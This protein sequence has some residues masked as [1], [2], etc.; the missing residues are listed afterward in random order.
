MCYKRQAACGAAVLSDQWC[1]LDSF[2]TP[3]EQILIARSRTDTLAALDM[4]DAQ[5]QSIGRQARAR[6]L[7]EHTSNHRAAQLISCLERLPAVAP[8]PSRPT[9]EPA[10]DAMRI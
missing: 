9:P 6:T 7:D 5:L 3:G 4:S 10:L 2:Y 8:H 1:G